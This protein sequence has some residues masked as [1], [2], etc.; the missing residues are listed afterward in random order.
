ML[1][2]DPAVGPYTYDPGSGRN[3]HLWIGHFVYI[4]PDASGEATNGV[5]PDWA[6]NQNVALIRGYNGEIPAGY[7]G[8]S[9]ALY[10]PPPPP[11]PTPTPKPTA[12]PTPAPTWTPPRSGDRSDTALGER[13]RHAVSTPTV[14]AQQTPAASSPL[15]FSLQQV[16]IGSNCTPGAPWALGGGFLLAAALLVLAAVFLMRVRRRQATPVPSSC[17]GS[18]SGHGGHARR[19]VR[20]N[21][22]GSASKPRGGGRISGGGGECGRV[23]RT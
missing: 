17:S 18:R 6:F 9:V 1:D 8:P 20:S 22:G 13:D 23:S 12:T 16:C 5:S 10:T 14:V 3:Q 11:P 15:S 2:P 19:R 7:A 21:R 4:R